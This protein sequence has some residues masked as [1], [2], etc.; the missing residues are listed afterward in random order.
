M[1]LHKPSVSS[2]HNILIWSRFIQPTF[3]WSNKHQTKCFPYLNIFVYILLTTY[4][5]C[6]SFWQSIHLVNTSKNE[7]NKTV[8]WVCYVSIFQLL[9]GEEHVCLLPQHPAAEV[10][11]LCLRPAPPDTQHSVWKHQPRDLF[12]SVLLH[13]CMHTRNGYVRSYVA[14]TKP[15]TL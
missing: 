15:Q 9:P 14:K 2:F 3:N 1:L 6:L 10:R 4:Q 8:K 11:A 12:V 7:K 5:K 13:A